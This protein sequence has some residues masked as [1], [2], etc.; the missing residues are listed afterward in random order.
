MNEK[1]KLAPKPTHKTRVI[2]LQINVIDEPPCKIWIVKGRPMPTRVLKSGPPKHALKPALGEPLFAIDVSGTMS[3]ME[4]PQ[5]S[6]VRPSIASL[7]PNITPNAFKRL[8]SSLAM[9]KIQTIA[10]MNPAKANM[11]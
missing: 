9:M 2:L 8:T 10:K 3:P 11:K 5:D 4:F 6:N 1:D 7:R